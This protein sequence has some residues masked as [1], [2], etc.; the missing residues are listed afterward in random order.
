MLFNSYAF[1]FCFL[2]IVLMF[3]FMLA[4]YGSITAAGWLGLASLFFYGYWSIKALPLLLASIVLN[5]YFGQ[6]LTTLN[7]YSEKYRKTCLFIALF[8][9]LAVLAFFKYAN[10]FINNANTVMSTTTSAQIPILDIALPIGISFF[11]F[12]QIA[13]LVDCWRGKVDKTNFVHYLL[14]VTYFPHLIAGPVLHHGQMIPQFTKL[15]GYKISYDKFIIGITIFTIGLAKKILLADPLGEY[16][17]L[18]FDGNNGIAPMFFLSW[19]GTIAYTFQ[20]YFDFSGYTDMAIGISYLFGISLPNNFNAPYKA[21][22]IIDFWRRWH[23]SLSTFLRDYLYIPLGGN[24]LGKFRRYINILVT[25]LLGGLWHG[26]NWTFVVWGLMHGVFLITNHLWRDFTYFKEKLN[27]K[28]TL[29]ASWLVTFI[30]ICI[31]WVMF[32]A[33]SVSSAIKIY[34]SM[35]GLNG[36]S[37]P[38]FL[39][40]KLMHI[41]A[42]SSVVFK[43][44]LEGGALDSFSL[45]YLMIGSLFLCMVLPNSIVVSNSIVAKANFTKG[46][47][48]GWILIVAIAKISSHASSEFLYFQ[49]FFL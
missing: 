3:F 8:L 41:S 15:G 28:F 39:R 40:E 47:I 17:S 32:R 37:L 48:I 5:Y 45:V 46:I 30:L 29:F 16:A 9:N 26:A 38:G 22:S 4:R 10:F 27:N 7:V 11:T 21:T 49:F 33:D 44:T 25:M 2:P 31:T 43:G 18:L 35:L 13:Y 34:R 6:K 24:K 23:I 36:V 20:I 42:F 12:T 1:I 19:F 14:F